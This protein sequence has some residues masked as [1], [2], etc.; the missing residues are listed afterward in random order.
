MKKVNLIKNI[1]QL[2]RVVSCA[3]SP[4]LRGRVGVGLLFFAFTIFAQAPR[5]FPAGLA[6]CLEDDFR[7][8]EKFYDATGGDNWVNNTG[9]FTSADMS[10]WWGITINNNGCD[11]VSI[12]LQNNNLKGQLVELGL[13]NLQ[14]FYCQYNKLS[15]SILNFKN[16]PNLQ[17]LYCNNNQL[18]GNIPDFTN[19]PNLQKF[20]CAS[21]KLLGDIPDFK[22]LPNLLV[23]NCAGNQLTGNIPDFTNL[24]NLQ[25]FGCYENQLSGNIP[26]FTK[27]PNLKALLCRDN[28]L[29]GN[30]PNFA[31]LPNLEEFYCD[32]NHLTGNI[33]NL[34]KLLKL[35]FFYC[36]NNLLNFGNIENQ[37]KIIT[38]YS[39]AP[40]KT[41]LPIS[42]KNNVIIADSAGTTLDKLTYQWYRSELFYKA[43]TKNNKLSN[44]SKSGIYYYSVKHNTLTKLTL[45]SD[46]LVLGATLKGKIFQDAN[47]NCTLESSEKGLPNRILRFQNVKDTV[48]T[49]T[50][51]LG[52]YEVAL[53]TFNYVIAL[54]INNLWKSCAIPNIKPTSWN[55]SL[56]QDIPMQ[57]AADCPALEVSLSTQRLRRCFDNT[58]FVTYDNKGTI[59]AQNAYILVDFDKYL[60]VKSATIPFTKVTNNTYRFEVGTV[61]LF[62]PKTFSVQVLVDCDSTKIGQTHCTTAHI[63]PDSLCVIPS[64]WDQSS[65]VVSAK[66]DSSKVKFN[67][68]NVGNAPTSQSL[69]YFVIEDQIIMLQ[70]QPFN[71]NIGEVKNIDIPATGKTY[72]LT[73]K[74]SANHPSGNIFASAAVEQCGVAPFS[75]GFVTQ[76]AD[77]DAEPWIDV[78]C[79]QNIGSYDPN[80]KEASPAG[81]TAAHLIDQNTDIEYQINFQ[82]YGTDTAF[83]VVVRDTLSNLLDYSTLTMGASSH[84]YT[85][86]FGNSGALE[87]NFTNVNLTPKAADEAK[88]QGFFKF[89]IAQKRDL[90][91]GKKITNKADIYFD[92]NLPITTN[93]TF[94]QVGK[95]PLIIVKTDDVATF[96]K[97]FKVKIQPNPFHYYTTFVVERIDNEQFNLEI[98]DLQG[99]KIHQQNFIENELYFEKP[100]PQGLYI[101]QIKGNNGSRS[102]GRFIVM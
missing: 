79:R 87:V 15:G 85:W 97:D 53:D 49:T 57:S 78:D 96:P 101:Y 99:N 58:Y 45:Y 29:T 28:K 32:Y 69:Q 40:Q 23:I 7:E 74:Q 35:N 92:F 11:I 56:T 10:T 3:S 61:G 43:I 95:N 71:L 84:T 60:K 102:S 18:T 39:Y 93:Q 50:D 22:N 20:I 83:T 89:R 63:Y 94:H 34:S 54:N 24:L 19:L 9:W 51:S 73:A 26:D 77:Q 5:P 41:K 42:Y 33:P 59:A 52:N 86:R 65:I 36:N 2:L 47:K 30:I 48:Y 21:N 44:F 67:I 14:N 88:S 91:F 13:Q 1:M 8:L 72:R 16:L 100:L 17:V 6:T 98:F 82:N 64:N 66:C 4:S 25:T 62:S 68:K 55:D 75:F 76:Y 46:T 38:N 31:N 90:P 81:A 70:S 12:S 27:L 80:S 37:K